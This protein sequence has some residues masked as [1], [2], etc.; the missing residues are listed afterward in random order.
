MKFDLRDFPDGFNVE[1]LEIRLNGVKAKQAIAFD[2][3]ERWIEELAHSGE[4]LVVLELVKVAGVD[5]SEFGNYKGLGTKTRVGAV[6]VF[7]R[8]DTQEFLDEYTRLA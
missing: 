5:I 1:G 3:A 2:T 7:L 8:C 4:S 6:E